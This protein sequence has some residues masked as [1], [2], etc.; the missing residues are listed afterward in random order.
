[1]CISASYNSIESLDL[2]ATPVT[3]K[4][5][6]EYNYRDACGGF[7]TVLL[8]IVFFSLISSFVGTFVDK[9]KHLSTPTVPLPEI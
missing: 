5:K 3:F 2:L 1:M 6:N 9:Q 4:Y 7:L 8:V